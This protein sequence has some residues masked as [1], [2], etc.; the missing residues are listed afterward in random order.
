MTFDAE[1]V[2]YELEHAAHRSRKMTSRLILH[3]LKLIVLLAVLAAAIGGSFLY[4]T[5]K[6]IVDQAPE[7]ESLTI[8]PLGI[9]STLYDRDGNAVETLIKSGSNRDPVAYS[10]VP[11]NLIKAFVAIEDERFWTHEGVDIRGVLRSMASLLLKGSINGGASTI[12]Q[13]LIKN[14]VFNGGSE[15]G[16]G[17][18]F[19]RK[20]QEQYLA[21]KLEKEVPKEEILISYLNSINLGQN[22]LGVQVASQ[23]YFGKDVGDLTLSECACIAG[24]TQNPYRY[25]PIRFP[26]NNEQRRLSVLNHMLD[27]KLITADEYAEALAD[28]AS[29]YERIAENNLRIRENSS[30]YTYFTDAVINQVLKDLQTEL[31]YSEDDAY[32]ML[33]SGGLNI[34]TTLDSSIQAIVDEEV[35]DP[36][37]YPEDCFKWSFTCQIMAETAD[38]STKT[39]SENQIKKE[40]QLSDLVFETK[41]E[42]AA[43]ITQFKKDLAAGGSSVIDEKV[44]YTLQPQLSAV[45]IDHTTGQ[46]LAICGGRGEKSVSR[47]FNR[48]TDTYRSPGSTFKILSTF[49]PG[50]D[51]REITLADWQNDLPFTYEG[52]TMRNWWDSDLWL[53]RCNARMAIVYSMNVISANFMVNKIGIE[54]AFDTLSQF[55]FTSLV[56]KETINGKVYSDIGPALCIGSLTKGVNLL[57][58]TDAFAAL[59][60]SGTYIEPTFYTRI[61][62]H[63][64]KVL[65]E[66]G[67]ESHRVVEPSTAWLL[68]SAMA[69][70][71]VDQKAKGKVGTNSSMAALDRGMPAAGKS[72]TSTD[73]TGK[74]RDYWFIGYTGYYTMGVWTGFDDGG[75]TLTGNI[76]KNHYQKVVWKKVMDRIHADKE[77]VPFIQPGN[78]VSARICPLCGKLAVS[79]LCDK[80]TVNPPYIEYFAMGTEPTEYCDCHVLI[81]IC[82]DSKCEAG[83]WC[84]DTYTKLYYSIP[85]TSPETVDSAKIYQYGVSPKVCTRH[86]EPEKKPEETETQPVEQSSDDSGE[87]ASADN[88][89][90]QADGGQN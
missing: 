83:P 16:W 86:K 90:G 8:S 35:N 89:G 32:T 70:S 23:R 12:T 14:N 13:Q 60:N 57:E 36:S 55:G 66:R 39:Y 64:G 28:T 25:N 87:Q 68:G 67:Q 47:S 24:I 20:F 33:Y 84:T 45:V 15:K 51:S 44:Y 85:K 73:S 34:Q 1:T 48:A 40:Y 27:Q 88:A 50:L 43:L 81:R 2:E 53:G 63:S 59:A 58:L 62:D 69:D 19:I 17:A 4:G 30:T 9:A 18:R 42:I 76:T 11:E 46:V 77:V 82:N 54:R 31:G 49:A 56:R 72:G 6:G 80:D 41:D 26:E 74:G 5:I 71:M 38:G 79:G 61:T 78:I 75:I 21:I 3:A 29:L 52:Y 22:S 37:N 7:A 10:A 65:L